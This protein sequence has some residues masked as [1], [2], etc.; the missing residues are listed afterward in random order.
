MNRGWRHFC[1][2]CTVLGLL[3][4]SSK[5]RGDAFQSQANQRNMLPGGRAQMLGGA[6]TAISDDAPGCYYN[7]AGLSF[8]RDDRIE[9]SGTA[10]RTTKLTY[11][12]AINDKPFEERSESFYPSFLGGTAKLG[13]L[14][15]GYAYMTLDARNVY[16]QD[17]YTDIFTND[18]KPSSYSRTY[19][20]NSTY[21]WAGAT[22]ALKLTDHISY[23]GSLFYYQRNIEFTTSQL[24]VLNGGGIY[25]R[26]DTLSTLNTGLASVNGLMF[27]G[28]DLSVGLSVRMAGAWSNRSRYY[29]DEITYDPKSVND[30]G[31]AEPVVTHT[32]IKYK[33]FNE[34]N[35]TTYTVGAAWW[36]TKWFLL[37]GDVMAHEGVKTPFANLGGHDLHTTFNYSA[38]TEVNVGFASLM[39]GYFTNNS[40]Y[41]APEPEKAS[42]PTHIDYRGVSGGM[43]W[44]LAG[45][46]GEL[47]YMTQRGK[48]EAQILTGS[49]AI[50]KVH[51]EISTYLISGKVP[52]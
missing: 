36:A 17:K 16:Q 3:V 39:A 32:E 35:P 31:N 28:E 34:M 43:S 24:A 25:S 45:F 48:G 4:G 18:G 41:R 1:C 40:M 27:H 44:H 49:R 30:A 29:S 15:V 20:E 26:N 7:P 14:T 50:Q 21:R 13:P 52:L 6:Y 37:T 10:Y 47:G 51:G 9:A 23:G 38:G 33:A 8:S 22:A 19:L 12:G 2:A 11:D 46:N 42:Q 5:A